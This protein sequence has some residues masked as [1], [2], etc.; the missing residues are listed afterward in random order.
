MELNA[1][2]CNHAEVQNNLLYLA[3][4][5]IDRASVPP[6]A[7]APYQISLAVGLTLG[8]PWTQTNQNH[9]LSLTLV[10]ADEQPVMV[11]VGP[12]TSEPLRADIVFN[13]GRPPSLI[14]GETQM[15]SLAINLP[16]LVL[17]QLG[18]YFF[19]LSVDGTELRRLGYAVMGQTGMTL[20]AGPTDLPR[21]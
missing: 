17:P 11:P 9:S 4:G 5:G 21:L 14:T 13:V 20:G 12:D 10:D 8:V 18:R 7:P 2:L 16:G 6:G 15:V 3:G 19:V 1:I